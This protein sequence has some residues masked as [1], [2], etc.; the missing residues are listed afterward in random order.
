MS[1]TNK[2]ILHT[3]SEVN[4]IPVRVKV[5]NIVC[6]QLFLLSNVTC[7]NKWNAFS[8]F[9]LLKCGRTQEF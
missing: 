3:G 1:F 6:G 4:A 2:L 7:R 5:I 9:Y 8:A